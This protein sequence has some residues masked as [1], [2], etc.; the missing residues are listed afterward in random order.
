MPSSAVLLPARPIT[1]HKP[2]RLGFWQGT[3]M[4]MVMVRVPLS[5]WKFRFCVWASVCV[6]S[7]QHALS[8]TRWQK[9]D[10]W[11]S[12]NTVANLLY[13]YCKNKS[14]GTATVALHWSGYSLHSASV[15]CSVLFCLCGGL[16]FGSSHIMY[17]KCHELSGWFILSDTTLI[18]SLP[19]KT[20]FEF[21]CT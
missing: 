18:S 20:L 9:Q 19:I 2:L 6:F 11:L 13:T 10:Y 4:F 3:C 15:F 7:G 1:N 8:K 17:R 14:I 12:C 16:L 21:D 5:F